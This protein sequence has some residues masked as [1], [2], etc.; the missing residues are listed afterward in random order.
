MAVPDIVP[1][2]AGETKAKAVIAFAD[3]A[4]LPEL[5]GF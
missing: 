3:D 5:V 2:T 1:V 4:V